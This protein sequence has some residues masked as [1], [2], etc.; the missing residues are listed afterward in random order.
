MPA[1]INRTE[2]SRGFPGSSFKY[3]PL[4]HVRVLFVGFVR[5]LFAA[6]PPNNYRWNE[7]EQTTEIIIRDENPI[8]VDTYGQRPCINFTLGRAQFY[9]L[10]MD[11]LLGYQFR[12]DAKTKS[13]LV[14][15]VMSVNI[16]ARSDIEAHNLAWVVGEHMWLLRDLM[17]KEGFFELGRGID[18]SPPGPPGSVIASDQADSWYLSSVSVP[19]QF[20]RTSTF[21][22]LGRRIVNS[23]ET[24][25]NVAAPQR[26][27]SMGWP[28][29]EHGYPLSIH[30]TPPASFAPDASDARGGTPDPAGVKENPLPR[31]PHPLNPA[32]TVVVRAVYPHRAGLRPASMNG[33]TLP[34]A[35]VSME[36]S[37]GAT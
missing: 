33:R 5:G 6:A 3:T 24:H 17:M 30:T 34:I 8:H 4:Q 10:G 2:S 31:M 7:D 27:E 20:V 18:V 11:D 16:S 32:K 35:T 14:P 36:E 9:S 19:W 22:P 26:V 23:I 13:V 21:T 29:A 12:T 15:G 28:H 1:S 37:T 25:M